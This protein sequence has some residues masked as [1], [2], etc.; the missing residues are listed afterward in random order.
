M[1]DE[2]SP[3]VSPGPDLR[4][5]LLSQPRNLE[6]RTKYLATRTPDWA[7]ADLR[8]AGEGLLAAR[9]VR[10][11]L[12]LAL[13]G[14]AGGALGDWLLM[15]S[16]Q[17]NGGGAWPVVVG[18]GSALSGALSFAVLGALGYIV[19][20]EVVGEEWE[21]QHGPGFAGFL[22]R[23]REPLGDALCGAAWGALCGLFIGALSWPPGTLLSLPRFG[24]FDRVLA[25]ASGGVLLG[26]SFA[27][28]LAVAGKKDDAKAS[29][30]TE[31]GP[32]PFQAY[33]FFLQAAR[34]RY[35]R[36]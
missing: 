24:E 14:A 4:E 32:L 21:T 18:V 22:S 30:W 26:A 8:L 28:V 12:G 15:N 19:L 33:F 20:P 27:L 7:L 36:K 6:L 3:P 2:A 31:L 11:I 17:G 23:V 1:Q 25:G 16:P 9:M 34:A 35:L 10:G 29:R 5:R 13:V